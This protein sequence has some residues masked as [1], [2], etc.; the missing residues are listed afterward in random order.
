MIEHFFDEA[1]INAI[2]D[3][4]KRGRIDVLRKAVGLDADID[5]PN[6]PEDAFEAKPK[7]HVNWWDD[8]F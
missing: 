7:K 3:A 1:H 8:P 5:K 2:H 4:Q 6:A